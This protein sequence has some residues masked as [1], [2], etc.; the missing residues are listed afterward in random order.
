MAHRN[1]GDLQA[2]VDDY[3]SS[4][5]LDPVSATATAIL[6]NRGWALRK[7][8]DLGRAVTDFTRCLE[9]GGES[10]SVRCGRAFA[11][12]QQGDL[13]RAIK[14]YTAV[15]LHDPCHS[16][17]LFNRCCAFDKLKQFHAA[18]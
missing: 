10:V 9:I 14:D 15:L 13:R 1:A 16:E 4:L 2:A 11:L 18:L 8:G 12:A 5:Q 3:T 7:L 17:A 6:S